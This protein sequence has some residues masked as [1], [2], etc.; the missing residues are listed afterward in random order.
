MYTLEMHLQLGL[1]LK[2]FSNISVTVNL[3]AL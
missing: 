2:A 3:S 1:D